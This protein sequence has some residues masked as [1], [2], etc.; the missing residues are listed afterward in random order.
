MKEEGKKVFPAF[1]LDWLT[2]E[3]WLIDRPEISLNT[4]VRC[5][6]L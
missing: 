5:V 1:F 6:T 3:V 4:V 2:F